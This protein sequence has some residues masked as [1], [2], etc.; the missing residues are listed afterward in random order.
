MEGL[1]NRAIGPIQCLSKKTSTIT[2]RL[3]YHNLLRVVWLLK[4]L[5]FF[6]SRAMP[7]MSAPTS[8]RKIKYLQSIDRK[9]HNN[10]RSRQSCLRDANTQSSRKIKKKISMCLGFHVEMATASIF[11][12]FSNSTTDHIW[13]LKETSISQNLTVIIISFLKVFYLAKRMSQ[14][15]PLLRKEG[16]E[17]SQFGKD[18][19]LLSVKLSATIIVK[20]LTSKLCL[21]LPTR[22]NLQSIMA[23]RILIKMKYLS[24][25][26]LSVTKI[27]DRE[28]IEI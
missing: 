5:T 11:Q 23:I 1:S 9:L 24:L 22:S 28:Q 6:G 2:I 13:R 12:M 17:S 15:K 4:N 10:R 16:Q 21:R 3:H 19:M 26:K 14:G 27:T 8:I 7:W 20:T 25:N 18:S